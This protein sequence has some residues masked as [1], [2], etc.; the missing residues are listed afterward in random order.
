ML[1]GGGRIGNRLP[2]TGAVNPRPCSTLPHMLVLAHRGLH[3]DIPENTLE[4]FARAID[5]GVDG[6]ETDVRLSRDGLLVL[7]HDRLAPD[8]REVADL[9]A[10]ELAAAAGYPVPTLDAAL[11]LSS[12]ILWN[13]EIKVPAALPATF[14]LV[15]RSART[16]RLL[17]TSFW[18][19]LVEPF[20]RISGVECGLLLASRPATFEGFA[21]LFPHDGRIWTAVWSYE[22]LDPGLLDQAVSLGFRSY[23]YGAATED[24][25]RRAADLSLAGVITDR[26]ELLLGT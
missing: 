4:A 6:I 11:A 3:R 23:V 9:T 2:G 5:L 10:A 25:H 8:G 13:I 19:S 7:F 18:H 24:E 14:S 26:P 21:G 15:E 1:S 17:V 20:T 12:A 16:H 22:V